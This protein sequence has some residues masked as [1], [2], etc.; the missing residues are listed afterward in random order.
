MYFYAQGIH[1]NIVLQNI[2]WSTNLQIVL[3]SQIWVKIIIVITCWACLSESKLDG[4]FHF[5]FHRGFQVKPWFK[6]AA[7]S[8]G[9]FNNLNYWYINH[10]VFL[11]F[12]LDFQASH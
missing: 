7:N 3:K 11:V 2:I 5:H 9:F 4:I 10:K 8:E 12:V 6:I 1:K